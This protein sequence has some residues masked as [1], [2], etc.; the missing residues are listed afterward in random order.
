M[1]KIKDLEI[2]KAYKGEGRNF[3]IGIWTGKG[4]LGLRYKFGWMQD[5]EQ[6]WDADPHYGT[7]KPEY[8]MK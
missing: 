7:F 8:E 5:V 2:G 6:H 4:F 3:D 1:I